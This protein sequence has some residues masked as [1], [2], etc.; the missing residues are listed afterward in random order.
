MYY[1]KIIAE[2]YIKT[3]QIVPLLKI[4]SEEHYAP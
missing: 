2:I 3:H 4:F 1:D